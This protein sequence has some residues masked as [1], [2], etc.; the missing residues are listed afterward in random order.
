MRPPQTHDSLPHLINTDH[1]TAANSSAGS[2]ELSNRPASLLR[3]VY[4]F[5]LS[6]DLN[7]ASDLCLFGGCTMEQI[8]DMLAEYQT[9]IE[10]LWY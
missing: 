10:V 6:K 3:R 7:R 2:K 5:M 1:P 8:D 9:I 4:P